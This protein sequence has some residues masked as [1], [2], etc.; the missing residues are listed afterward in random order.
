MLSDPSSFSRVSVMAEPF[1]SDK[2]SSI[3]CMI[4]SW[5]PKVP[6]LPQASPVAVV[7]VSAPPERH[8]SAPAPPPTELIKLYWVAKA[9][10][11][12]NITAPARDAYVLGAIILL[13]ARCFRAA[14]L[15]IQCY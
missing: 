7:I 2:S 5:L 14:I 15:N 10:W 11:A 6:V 1:C 9:G 3:I 4:E 13:R 12:S 8:R